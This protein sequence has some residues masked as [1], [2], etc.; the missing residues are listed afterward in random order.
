M[1]KFINLQTYLSMMYDWVYELN[2][3]DEKLV[4]KPRKSLPA[5]KM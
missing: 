2:G 4:L 1:R 5:T 3:V